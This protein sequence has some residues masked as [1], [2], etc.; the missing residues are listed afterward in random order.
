MITFSRACIFFIALTEWSGAMGQVR[1]GTVEHNRDLYKKG[2]ITESEETFESWLTGLKSSRKSSIQANFYTIPVVVHIIHKGEPVGTGTNISDAQVMSQIKVL[3]ND[4]QRLNDDAVRTPASFSQSAGSMNISFVLASVDPSG[5][6]TS[7]IVRV[8]GNLSGYSRSENDDAKSLS[9]W[10]SEN[11][12]NIWVCN[13]TD[14]FGFTQFPISTLQGLSASGEAYSRMT[15]GIIVS[16]ASFGSVNDG[17]FNLDNRYNEGRILTHEMGHFFGLRH[18][19]GD[20]EG[21]SST[22]FIDDTPV[23][24]EPTESCPTGVL[25]DCTPQGRMYQNYMDYTYDDC[26]NLFTTDQVERMKLV[27]ENSPRRRSLLIASGDIQP[28]PFPEVFSPNGDGIN[29]FWQWENTLEYENCRLIIYDRFG[30][31][32]LD[33]IGYDNSWS[34]KSL[35]GGQLEEEA[36]Y[37][38]IRCENRKSITGAVRIVR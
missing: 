22:D 24:S 2:I 17:P 30:T 7:G 29:D 34:G 6:S 11:Y 12:L 28:V 8:K 31:I 26:M 37:Y 16:Y 3:N 15:D 27:L 19:W 33:K 1:C 25:A 4:F 23:Q 38:E 21:C 35:R 9:F 36:Y 13:L 10:P 5:K 18:T 32:V 20:G 14:Y